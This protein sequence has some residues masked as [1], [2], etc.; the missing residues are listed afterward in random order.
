M[1]KD[2]Y[3]IISRGFDHPSIVLWRAVEMRSIEPFISRLP[4]PILDLGCAEGKI[5]AQLFDGRSAHGLDNCWDLLRQNT[6]G[7]VYRS[8]VL[9]DA[10][11]MP[12]HDKAFGSVFSNC[13]IE[14]IP[15][16]DVLLHEVR[17]VL[18]P[19]GTLLISVP[20]DTFPANLYFTRLF[21]AL[22]LRGFARRYAAWRNATLRHYHCYGHER[23]REIFR[24][25]GF[26]L[27]AQEYYLTQEATSSWDFAAGLNVALRPFGFLASLRENINKKLTKRLKK[28]YNVS[29]KTGSGLVLL[30]R[31]VS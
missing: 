15:D 1:P 28:Y 11:R 5:G 3:D 2:W 4:E 20:S 21:S 17:R 18:K 22:R 29:S 19:Q 16:L 26:E 10:C 6:R 23:W 12:Y 13:V 30:A 25:H 8:L 9:G 14:H 24:A 27:L 7:H 31:A